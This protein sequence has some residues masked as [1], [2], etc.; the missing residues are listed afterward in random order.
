M[1]SEIGS[2]FWLDPE[3]IFE[4]KEIDGA[5][6]DYKYADSVFTSSG[7]SAISFVLKDIAASGR[8]VAL[9]PI[10][11]CESVIQPFIDMGYEPK[12][13]SVNENLC[14]DK[15]Q[16]W[17]E[18]EKTNPTVI[19]VHSYFGFNTLRE[20]VKPIGQAGKNGV[21]IIE[22]TTQTLYSSYKKL[23]ADYQ[24][25]SF[26]KWA[27]L[28]DGGYALKKVGSFKDKPV[29]TDVDFEKI[30]LDA[31]YAKHEYILTGTG[32]KSAFLE[33]YIQAEKLLDN[34]DKYYKISP[35]SLTVQA[36]LDLKE[37]TEKR[38]NNYKILLN[39][40]K[41]NGVFD[42]IFKT[43]PNDTVPLYFPVICT[44]ERKKVQEYLREKQIYAPIVWTKSD[45]LKEIPVS[46]LKLYE[47]ML[48]IPC[49]QR[50]DTDDMQRIIEICA[51]I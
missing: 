33:K 22:D 48:C 20:L 29:K 49:D 36:N 38:R 1:I 26:R 15:E 30:K 5:V 50:Y 17:K 31:M 32:D 37:L 12:F 11:T 16:F 43:L 7:R 45:L 18:I 41:D 21:K 24:I 47:K 44:T 9:L 2:N 8:K 46:A 40:L 3:E 39:G 19:L 28:P 34:Q 42:I 23:N 6:F 35:S 13:Y 10:Y 51:Q 4:K 25:G 27:G 14:C